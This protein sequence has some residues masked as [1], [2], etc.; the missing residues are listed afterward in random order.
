[1]GEKLD[2]QQG[3]AFKPADDHG[4]CLCQ[5]IH[6]TLRHRNGAEKFTETGAGRINSKNLP[7]ESG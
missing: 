1:M 7:R 4:L 2:Q 5:Q 6:E 3:R